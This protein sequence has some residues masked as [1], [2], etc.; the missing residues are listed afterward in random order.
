[1]VLH[2]TTHVICQRAQIF[3]QVTTIWLLHNSSQC[4]KF[5]RK[6]NMP[7]SWFLARLGKLRYWWVSSHCLHVHTRTHTHTHTHTEDVRDSWLLLCVCGSQSGPNWHRCQRW[8]TSYTYSHD[9]FRRKHL[10]QAHVWPLQEGLGNWDN[11]ADWIIFSS[12]QH[13]RSWGTEPCLCVSRGAVH[14]LGPL[15]ED[16]GPVAE[17]ILLSE[18]RT[19]DAGFCFPYSFF[20]SVSIWVMGHHSSL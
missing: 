11:D 13:V 4:H 10:L 16:P 18:E 20:A 9:F 2:M 15:L 5:P 19:G 14:V 12:A 1:M 8:R 17:V 3:C 7:S 6:L